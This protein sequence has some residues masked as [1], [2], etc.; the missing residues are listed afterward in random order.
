MQSDGVDLCRIHFVQDRGKARIGMQGPEL[1]KM[2]CPENEGR[3]PL[4]PGAAGGGDGLFS[5]SGSLSGN[6]Q[7]RRRDVTAGCPVGQ[8]PVQGSRFEALA[9]LTQYSGKASDG[10]GVASG[11]PGGSFES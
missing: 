9:P 7:V 6:R 3:L 11:S 2:P 10:E 5:K 8:L 1:R 4:L